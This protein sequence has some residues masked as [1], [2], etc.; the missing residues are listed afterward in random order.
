LDGVPFD[1]PGVMRMYEKI[2]VVTRKTRLEELVERFNTAGQAKF[3]IEHSGGDFSQYTA[4]DSAYRRSLEELH[5]SLEVGLKLQWIDR[6]LAPTFLFTEHDV[7][8]TVG[9]DGLVANTAKYAG[10]QPLVAVNP[11]RDRI[12]GILLPFTPRTVRGALEKVLEGQARFREVTMAEVVLIDGQKLLAFN[13]LFIG[14]SSHVSARYWM[15]W[16]GRGESQSSSGVIVSTGAGS[17]G[18]LS[19]LFTMASGITEF[20][21][22]NAGRGWSIPWEDPRLVFAVREPFISRHSKADIVAGMVEPG[23]DLLLESLM[24]SGG[25]IFSDGIE[26]DFLAFNAGAAAHVRA[27]PQRAR[28]VAAHE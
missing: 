4:E 8:V 17:T 28:L 14:A 7:V 21:G 22:G 18:W 19:S 27:A 5:R 9:Q 16:N 10:S 26:A 1:L 23:Q 13:D 25:V 11:D 6:S 2:V 12:D 20:L 24:P 3:Y 15:Q